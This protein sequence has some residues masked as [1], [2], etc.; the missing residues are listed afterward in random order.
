MIDNSVFKNHW[1]EYHFWV[2]QWDCD[3]KEEDKTEWCDCEDNA[4]TAT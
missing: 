2:D 1:K 3:W 4:S